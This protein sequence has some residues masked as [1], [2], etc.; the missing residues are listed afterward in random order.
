[1]KKFSSSGMFAGGV[2]A[3]LVIT[4][5]GAAG[6]AN[7]NPLLLGQTNKASKI[8]ELKTGKTPLKLTSKQGKAPLV[9][10]SSK[11]VA[12][13]NADKLDG[14]SSE[15]FALVS[16]QTADIEANATWRDVD[17]NGIL[18]SLWAQ[19]MCPAGS[20]LTG[21]GEEN[22]SSFST[23]ASVPGPTAG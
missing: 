15:S 11:K 1:M 19:R 17:N 10:N 22:F 3:A 14:V 8:T 12:K 2:V 13:L 5:G 23:L 18:D 20:K 4:G 9:V 7:G 6:A 21:G 16:G